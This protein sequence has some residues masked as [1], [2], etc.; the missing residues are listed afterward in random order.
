MHDKLR[1]M[2]DEGARLRGLLDV[3]LKLFLRPPPIEHIKIAFEYL[4]GQ[5][6]TEIAARHGI[7]QQAVSKAVKRCLP[8]IATTQKDFS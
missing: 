1:V 4:N 5:K 6:Q 3:E 8:L 2:D 7:S